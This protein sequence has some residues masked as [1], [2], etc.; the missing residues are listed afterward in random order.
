[1]DVM[2]QLRE[3]GVLFKKNDIHSGL[4]KLQEIWNNVPEPKTDTLNAYLILEY[5]VGL[6]L[7]VGDLDEAQ[8]WADFA[9][10]FALKRHDSGEVEFLRGKVA[11]ARGDLKDAKN[12]FLIANT[13]SEG[14]MFEGE[15]RSYADLIR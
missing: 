13:K 15:D 5:G 2:S 3:V 1:M 4:Q 6:A 8:R 12:W 14:R 10:D 11:F 9:P 7:K